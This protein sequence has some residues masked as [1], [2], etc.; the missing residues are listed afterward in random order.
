MTKVL[1]IDDDSVLNLLLTMVLEGEGYEVVR[2]YDGK[3]G[4]ELL[5]KEQPEIVITDMVMPVLDGVGFLNGVAALS[6]HPYKII[7]ISSNDSVGDRRHLEI[8]RELGAH[9]VLEKPL[10]LGLLVVRIK[11]LLS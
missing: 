4:L 8:A 1:V 7:V 10:D 5:H 2:A 3:E 11:S 6:Q 9:D